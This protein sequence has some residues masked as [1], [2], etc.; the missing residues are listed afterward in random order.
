MISKLIAYS[1]KDRLQAI[2]GLKKALDYYVI[3]GIEQNTSFLID[4]LRNDEFKEGKTPTN[5]IDMHYP[6]GFSG[7]KLDNIEKAELVAT[8]AAIDSWRREYL[9]CPSLPCHTIAEESGGEELIVC[10]GGMFGTVSKVKAVDGKM[11]IQ[12][13]STTKGNSEKDSVVESEH[14]ISIESIDYHPTNPIVDVT[15]N[16]ADHTIQI[17]T[18]TNN[19]GKIHTRYNGAEYDCLVMSLEEYRLSTYMNEPKELDTSNYLLSPMPG[20]LVSYAVEDGDDVLV[21][22][23]ICIVEAMKMQNVL[24]SS[25]AGKVKKCHA[26]VGSSLKTDEMIVEF[27]LND[28]E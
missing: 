10:V 2:E 4:V 11:I 17:Q 1:P 27:E 12:H 19:I 22:Q 24:R 25:R 20:T 7:V 6:D 21:G 28:T 18:D 15:L 14:E 9:D 8:V 23:E 13:L 3:K 5:F 16:G 26:S